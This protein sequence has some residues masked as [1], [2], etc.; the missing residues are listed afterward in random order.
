[1]SVEYEYLVYAQTTHTLL[2]NDTSIFLSV[3]S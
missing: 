2:K 1:M 3:V